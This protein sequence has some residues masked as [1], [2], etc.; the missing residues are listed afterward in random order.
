[1]KICILIPESIGQALKQTIGLFGDFDFV[2]NPYEAHVVI[3][4]SERVLAPYYC[5]EREFIIF[6]DSPLNDQEAKNVHEFG[7]G[8]ALETMTLPAIL[9]QKGLPE[10]LPNGGE[11]FERRIENTG[12]LRILVVDDTPKHQHSAVVLLPK[13]DLTVATSYDEAMEFLKTERYDIVLTDMEMPMSMKL[14]SHILGKLI[15]YGLLIEKEAVIRGVKR[16]GVVTNLN[17]HTDPFAAAFDHFSSH[18]YTENSTVVKYMHAPMTN[19][20]EAYAKD[21]KT[22]LDKLM[23]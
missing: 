8:Q 15:P 19:I 4:D 21:W 5:K 11:V 22:A 18:V 2:N 13:Y 14:S 9:A 20:G 17:H 3:A 16:V 23:S 6:S 12:E 1:M 7:I 10:S